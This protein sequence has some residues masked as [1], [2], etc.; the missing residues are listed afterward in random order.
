MLMRYLLHSLLNKT[1]ER[2]LQTLDLPVISEMQP[3][4]LISKWGI[5]GSSGHS[6]YK[7][8]FT[9]Q[10]ATDE[11]LFLI[12]FVPLKLILDDD[13]HITL[14]VNPKPSSTVIAAQ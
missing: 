12:C 14:W 5:D 3:A 11:Y 6:Q 2:L 10:V 7:E 8:K 4:K 9:D 1:T 13:S